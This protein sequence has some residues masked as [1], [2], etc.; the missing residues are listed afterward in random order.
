MAAVDRDGCGI[1]RR[2]HD[3]PARLDG[4]HVGF[5]AGRDRGLVDRWPRYRHAAPRRRSSGAADLVRHYFYDA[6]QFGVS[7][8]GDVA[9]A[10]WWRRAQIDGGSARVAGR[11]D[12]A[13]GVDPRR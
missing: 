7:P 8:R 5:F 9:N 4:I 12:P 10:G 2:S 13:G 3:H 1:F 6:G 11:A